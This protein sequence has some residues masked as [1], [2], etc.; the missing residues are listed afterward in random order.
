[1][2]RSNTQPRFFQVAFKIIGVL[3]IRGKGSSTIS[4]FFLLASSQELRSTHCK[5]VCLVS[6]SEDDSNCLHD[7]LCM[8]SNLERLWAGTPVSICC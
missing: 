2:N 6:V 3:N 8:G 7:I 5:Q 1:M 4:C